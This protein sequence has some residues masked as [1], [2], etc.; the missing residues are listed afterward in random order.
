MDFGTTGMSTPDA[1]QIAPKGKIIPRVL[2][3]RQETPSDKEP[4]NSGPVDSA[5]SAG[6]G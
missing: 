4:V 6:H 2:C 3:D 1:A 5:E